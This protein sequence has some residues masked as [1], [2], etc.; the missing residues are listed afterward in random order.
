MIGRNLNFGQSFKIASP[1]LC[2]VLASCAG[3]I[4]D[5]NPTAYLNSAAE[6]KIIKTS[7]QNGAQDVALNATIKLTFNQ[8]IEPFFPAHRQN[9][10][11][12]T[13]DGNRVPGNAT[14]NGDLV[15]VPGQPGVLVSEI[16]IRPPSRYF[17]PNTDYVLMWR[18][19][20]PKGSSDDALLS[21][22]HAR[23]GNPPDRLASGSIKFRTGSSFNQTTRPDVEVLAMSP[24]KG[25][26]N[27][28]DSAPTLLD[29]IGEYVSISANP[30]IQL[31]MTEP[32]MHP[33]VDDNPQS[34]SQE[35]PWKTICSSQ[36][37]S[38]CFMGVQIGVLDSANLT[39]QFLT[40]MTNA[41]TNPSLWMTFLNNYFYGR[42][43]GKIKTEHGRRQITF[44]IANGTTYPT[45]S[46]QAIVVILQGWLSVDSYPGIPP[47]TLKNGVFA[48]G[49]LHVSEFSL[50]ANFQNL[51]Q[52]LGGS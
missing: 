13:A 33:E 7:P 12:W 35:I 23:F 1:L 17:I 15:E 6:L 5:S 40:D 29:S 49:F 9:F 25:L 16:S 2:L 52:L 51:Q 37:S 50:P 21:G 41:A 4:E 8:E 24:G 42:L 26:L 28:P 27:S 11:L 20:P 30:Q 22:I 39:N 46:T 38:N 18:E 10:E 47:R 43:P 45:T 44:E 31:L 14:V 48:G 36:V 34:L 32:V 3:G 19:A